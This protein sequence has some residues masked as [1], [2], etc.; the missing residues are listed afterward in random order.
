MTYSITP[1]QRG[2][3]N[4]GLKQAAASIQTSDELGANLVTTIYS[5][6]SKFYEENS[7]MGKSMDGFLQLAGKLFDKFKGVASNA[8]LTKYR[9]AE[10]YLNIYTEVSKL[11]KKATKLA[12]GTLMEPYQEWAN[13]PDRPGSIIFVPKLRPWTTS[14]IKSLKDLPAFSDVNIN[15]ARQYI[16]NT[17]PGA[18]NYAEYTADPIIQPRKEEAPPKNW[19]V[20]N[21]VTETVPGV[22]Q[23][24]KIEGVAI[25]YIPNAYLVS[26]ITDDKKYNYWEV[27]TEDC[28][29]AIRALS[30]KEMKL[31]EARRIAKEYLQ[32]YIDSPRDVSADKLNRNYEAI[33]KEILDIKALNPTFDPKSGIQ[34]YIPFF[35]SAYSILNLH[36]DF[37]VAMAED[38]IR[39][40]NGALKKEL[41]QKYQLH[42][43]EIALERY[44]QTMERKDF[45][46]VVNR[47]TTSRNLMVLYLE[48]DYVEQEAKRDS[49]FF[50]AFEAA[51]YDNEFPAEDKEFFKSISPRMAKVFR[52]V[53]QDRLE[54]AMK[55]NK[56]VYEKFQEIQ[57]KLNVYERDKQKWGRRALFLITL[58]LEL[59]L[60]YITAGFIRA[61]PARAG[62]LVNLAM[63]AIKQEIYLAAGLIEKRDMKNLGIEAV[64]SVATM[65]IATALS[66]KLSATYN[67]R[68]GRFKQIVLDNL[69]VNFTAALQQELVH[70][71]RKQLSLDDFLEEL[72]KNFV[73]GVMHEKAAKIA[74]DRFKVSN[75]DFLIRKNDPSVIA[76]PDRVAGQ[77]LLDRKKTGDVPKTTSTED[78][79]NYKSDPGTKLNGAENKKTTQPAIPTLKPGEDIHPNAASAFSKA[80]EL[81]PDLEVS[82]VAMAGMPRLN[83]KTSWSGRLLLLN[84]GTI[85][86]AI[87]MTKTN[88]TKAVRY[89]KKAHKINSNGDIIVNNKGEVYL[90]NPK[91][92]PQFID[93]V[94]DAI[95]DIEWI[96]STEAKNKHSLWTTLFGKKQADLIMKTIENRHEI[97]GALNLDIRM[98]QAHHLVPIEM[99]KTHQVAQA[100]VAGGF[101]YNGRENAL[102]LPTKYHLENHDQYNNNVQ[103]MLTKWETANPGY[104]PVMARNFLEVEVVPKAVAFLMLG[105]PMN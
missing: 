49:L 104:T 72:F 43:I 76:L 36:Y 82:L 96:K 55:E 20:Q 29:L 31:G 28:A 30:A 103:T 7:V 4:P 46:E 42:K 60:T 53:E 24:K 75:L 25:R 99:L 84:I 62:L 78:T 26:L 6:L 13:D 58:A 19:F 47:V 14:R 83:I 86:Q 59:L 37:G 89:I 79:V 70:L 56:V 87:N 63:P 12:D 35:F 105:Q 65:N 48:D 61:I 93:K 94:Q 91:G 66:S 67:I 68:A 11:E 22:P 15:E 81:Q 88:V 32:K 74:I 9:W 102:P 39:H 71:A 54:E 5:D 73:V 44:F 17:I 80:P 3:S 2:T 45:A 85:A 1:T 51:L 21:V 77:K 95:K 64:T 34:A 40:L 69:L 38:I 90:A 57:Q 18:I 16:L 97:R 92:K 41:N 10:A 98:A 100:A 33:K 27:R 23:E 8:P 50:R 101:N 52:L